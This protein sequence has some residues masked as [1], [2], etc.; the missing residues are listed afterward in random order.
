MHTVQKALGFSSI[1]WLLQELFVWP[2]GWAFIYELSGC[3]FESR[4]SHLNFRYCTCF[5]QGVPWHSG[6]YRVWIHSE[7]RTWHEKKIQSELLCLQNITIQQ[8]R[9]NTHKFH[10]HQPK[11]FDIAIYYWKNISMR[12]DRLPRPNYCGPKHVWP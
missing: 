8:K 1:K 9:K 4:C 2:N 7:M 5:E 10:S 6:K 3:G 11:K 12:N